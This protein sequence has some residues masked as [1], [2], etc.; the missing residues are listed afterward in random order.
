VWPDPVVY[1]W[2]AVASASY[3]LPTTNRGTLL[4]VRLHRADQG[5]KGR[6]G[7]E[8]GGGRGLT[9]GDQRAVSVKGL[10]YT[11]YQSFIPVV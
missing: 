2:T 1:I 11:E 9:E 3:L 4:S 7:L 5:G 10:Y 8:W 6:E